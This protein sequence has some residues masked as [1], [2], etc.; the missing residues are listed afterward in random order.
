MC[1]LGLGWLLGAGVGCYSGFHKRSQGG[2]LASARA[3][4]PAARLGDSVRFSHPTWRAL[5]QTRPPLDFVTRSFAA[6]AAARG[7]RAARGWRLRPRTVGTPM[8]DG[9]ATRGGLRLCEWTDCGCPPPSGHVTKGRLDWAVRTKVK[10]C[11]DIGMF[12]PRCRPCILCGTRAWAGC[13]LDHP[14]VTRSFA[15]TRSIPLGS[16]RV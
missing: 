8:A 5:V 11:R 9:R 7:R 3:N 6:G 14:R 4:P 1:H 15:A 10:S 16:A 13:E 12:E 2:H